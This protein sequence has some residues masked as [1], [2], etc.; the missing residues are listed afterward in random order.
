MNSQIKQLILDS[1]VQKINEE[2][3]DRMI[4]TIHDAVTDSMIEVLG[5]TIDFDKEESFE[6]LMEICG[7]VAIVGLPE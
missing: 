4:D 6:V 5:D 7:R 1:A 2:V 3:F